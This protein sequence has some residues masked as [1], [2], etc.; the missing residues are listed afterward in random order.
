M[1]VENRR[2][3]RQRGELVF[4]CL[5]FFFYRVLV[6]G[7][8]FFLQDSRKKSTDLIVEDEI[9]VSSIGVSR[10]EM[11]KGQ[12][13]RRKFCL[14]SKAWNLEGPFLLYE[15]RSEHRI[16]RSRRSKFMSLSRVE[17]YSSKNR[18]LEDPH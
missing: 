8:F 14:T 15:E 11:V 16:S 9:V 7:V 6:V 10:A 18:Y 2:K 3:T 4:A 13:L 1:V 17:K 12:Y 5:G